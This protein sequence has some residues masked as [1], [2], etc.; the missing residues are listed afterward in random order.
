MSPNLESGSIKTL[1]IFN[2]IINKSIIFKNKNR[3]LLLYFNMIINK[4]IITIINYHNTTMPYCPSQINLFSFKINL[5]T[6]NKL[7]SIT[8]FQ[9][10][11]LKIIY[12][13]NFIRKILYSMILNFIVIIFNKNPNSQQVININLCI[14]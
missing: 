12:K 4:S 11:K 7:N 10:L 8:I 9:I 3:I 2:L 6:F 1:F 13:I 5:N 14:L